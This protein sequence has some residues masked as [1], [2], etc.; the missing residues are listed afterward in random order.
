MK[1]NMD[2]QRE[3]DL[4]IAEVQEKLDRLHKFFGNRMELEPDNIRWGHVGDVRHVIE[5]LDNIA[6]SFRLWERKRL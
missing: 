3:F 5:E 4:K 1:D 6:E 2:V